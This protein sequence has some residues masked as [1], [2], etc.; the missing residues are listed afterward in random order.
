MQLYLKEVL[1]NS[2]KLFPG[3]RFE[4][5]NYVKFDKDLYPATILES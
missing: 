4:T 2:T 3:E 5:P 1:S